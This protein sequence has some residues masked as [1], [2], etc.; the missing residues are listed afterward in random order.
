MLRS[1]IAKAV[2]TAALIAGAL[3]AAAA[4]RAQTAEP[5]TAAPAAA[6]DGG[7]TLAEIVVTAQK[8][9]ER[10]LDV[11]INVTSISAEQLREDRAAQP[12]DLPSLVANVAVKEN[13]PGAQSIIT[14]RGVGLDDFSSTNNSPVGVYVDDVFLASFAEYDFT[15]FD[16]ERVEVL[17]GPQGTLYG[18]NSTAGAI[19][20]ISAPPTMDAVSGSVEA[21]YGNYRTAEF[22]GVLN[23]PVSDTFALRLAAKGVSQS[24]GYWYSSVLQS[25]MGEQTN[26][27]VR[28][29]AL[30]KASEAWSVL[31]KFEGERERSGIGVGKFFGDIPTAPGVLCPNF[32]NPAQC[33]GL[34]GYTDTN[35][36]P[37]VGNWNHAAPYDV[38]KVNGTVH[39]DGDLGFA[40]FASVTGFIDFRRSFYIDADASPYIEAEFDQNDD[41]RQFSQEFRLSGDTHGASW[42][43]GLYYSWDTVNSFTPGYLVDLLQADAL[44]TSYQKTQ[45]EAAFGQ[46]KWPLPDNLSLT[47]GLRYTRETK[48]YF[49]GTSLLVPPPTFEVTVPVTYLDDSIEDINWSW[50]VGL[51][52]KVSENSLLYVSVSTG[53]KSGGFFN[54]ITLTDLA[55]AP[56]KSETLTDYEI[57][58]KTENPGHTLQFGSSI[59]YYDYKDLQTQTF[60]SVGA[61]GLIKLGNVS[62]ATVYGA[63]I[64]LTWLPI[65]GATLRS[66]VGLLHTDL[67]SFQTVIGNGVVTIP[68]GNQLPNAAKVTFNQMAGYEFPIAGGSWR[69][70]AQA[71]AHYSDGVFAEALNTWYLSS[72]ANWL[73]DARTAL[74]SGDHHQEIALWGKNLANKQV[75]IQ[76]TDDGFGSGYRIFNAPRTYGM[77]YLY[78]W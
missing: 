13:I 52:Y 43:G 49:G 55:L 11:G 39:V 21:S 64:D 45:S 36:D 2:C 15:M 18:R 78:R 37:F 35:P 34:Y 5:A 23:L 76:E 22:T 72:P 77:S 68:S 40:K 71:Q 48:S 59:F 14:I 65:A 61:V 8:R 73:L 20:L 51:D 75:P 70:G 66:S 56:Y 57:G 38:D 44:L 60:T 7:A 17:K 19:N 46:V 3:A 33:V 10:L 4:A 74:S 6:G 24:D 29:Q 69:L 16:L 9:S 28:L 47:T 27:F 26:A 30:W 54:G 42:L 31:L 53:E 50:R 1:L 32:K 25:D 58:F 62:T 12:S 67:G 41:V 63:D